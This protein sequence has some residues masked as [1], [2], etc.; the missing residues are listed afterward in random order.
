MAKQKQKLTQKPTAGESLRGDLRLPLHIF[1]C[2]MFSVFPLMVRDYT[3]LTVTKY[4]TFLI[5]AI[6]LIVTTGLASLLVV[7]D[8]LKWKREDHT[9][10]YASPD[11][12]LLAFLVAGVVSFLFSP[13]KT[14][15]NPAGQSAFLFGGGRYDGFVTMLLYAAVFWIVSRFGEYRTQHTVIVGVTA[16]LMCVVTVIQ[17]F[18]A[19]ALGLYAN[20]LGGITK[21]VSTVGNMGMFSGVFCVFVPLIVTSYVLQQHKRWV[22][23]VL[24][25]AEF[26]S[27][28]VLFELGV[29]AGK[30]AL[31]VMFAVLFP[32]MLRT[33]DTTV[34]LMDILATFSGA[35]A[36]AVFFKCTFVARLSLTRITLRPCAEM[37]ALLGFALVF[38]VLRF[39]L[40]RKAW[41]LTTVRVVAVVAIALLTLFFVCVNF[42]VDSVAENNQSGLSSRDELTEDIQNIVSGEA[43]D[44]SGS[45]RFGIWS[46]AVELGLKRPVF[47]TGIGT[48]R[49]TFEN[50]IRGTALAQRLQAVDMAHN[51]YLHLFCT[52]GLVGLLL[53]LGFL[54]TLAVRA[55]KRTDNPRV[56][57][58]GAAVLC[59]A[60][61]A[62]FSF[63]IVIITP[64]FWLTAG[65]LHR[66]TRDV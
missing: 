51:E 22:S 27:V 26:L 35:L 5:L 18:G 56:L 65:L 33:A 11:V 29:T 15:L 23:A 30:L 31:L 53:Y 16:I 32:F 47:G 8:G 36:A 57:I 41:R 14:L 21:F 58:L 43:T 17:L 28:Y 44:A 24:L 34:K 39:L 20:F 48:F 1:I 60:V 37:F 64:L 40:S 3:N 55:F 61:Q 63:S 62:F 2:L 59:Y 66:E 25:V 10:W 52:M 19:N 13:Y 54:V 50:H 9:P 46:N 12:Y 42:T 45:F 6:L 4:V 49:E 38:A 7:F